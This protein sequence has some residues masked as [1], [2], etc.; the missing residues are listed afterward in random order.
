MNTL[1][2]QFELER[3]KRYLRNNPDQ[4]YQLAIKSTQECIVVLSE[5]QKLQI[6]YIKLKAQH[7]LSCS[8]SV[9]SESHKKLQQDYEKLQQDYDELLEYCDRLYT[10]R[11]NLRE[12]NQALSE[13]VEILASSSYELTNCAQSSISA[14]ASSAIF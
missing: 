8:S 11:V 6:K 2:T 3:F 14:K 12:H 1:C 13:M 10:D 7:K 9:S 5:H 4:A